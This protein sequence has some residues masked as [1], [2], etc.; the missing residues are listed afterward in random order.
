MNKACKTKAILF[1]LALVSGKP[2]LI[3]FS[4]FLLIDKGPI[5]A[6]NVLY[7]RV[8]KRCCT[9]GKGLRKCLSNEILPLSLVLYFTW[10][11]TMI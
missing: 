2:S 9:L 7:Y 4:T 10:E 11:I 3:E 8:I 1:F 5:R 6:I